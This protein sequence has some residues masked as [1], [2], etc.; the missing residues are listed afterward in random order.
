MND[1]IDFEVIYAFNWSGIERW[2][3]GWLSFNS[4]EL[5]LE[6]IIV[7]QSTITVILISYIKADILSLNL[8]IYCSEIGGY[9]PYGMGAH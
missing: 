9:D 1:W 5:W 4:D 6:K 3:T 2:K 8:R 7:Q